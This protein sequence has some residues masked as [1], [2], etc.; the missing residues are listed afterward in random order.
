MSNNLVGCSHAQ[1]EIYRCPVCNSGTG[2]KKR[3][4]T[5]R[6]ESAEKA[7]PLT[8]SPSSGSSN[9]PK[10]YAG[11]FQ[12]SSAFDRHIIERHMNIFAGSYTHEYICTLCKCDSVT[13]KSLDCSARFSAL[14]SEKQKFLDHLRT[15]HAG[16]EQVPTW[17][18]HPC[19]PPDDASYI[20]PVVEQVAK[21]IA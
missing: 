4:Y 14:S 20:D 3:P 21:S 12:L 5:S 15:A 13:H 1:R 6:R 2:H 18:T 7:S 11:E 17:H 16:A 10:M 9:S 19:S 8:L